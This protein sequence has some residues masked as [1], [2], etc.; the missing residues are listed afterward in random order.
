PA[1]QALLDQLKGKLPA[2]LQSRAEMIIKSLS[3]G[4]TVDDIPPALGPL[5]RRSVQPYAISSFKYD[6]AIEIAKLSIH[7][8]IT[9][10]TTDIQEPAHEANAQ[11]LANSAASIL[12]T[13]ALNHPLQLVGA[14][15]QHPPPPPSPTR[16]EVAD[17]VSGA[18]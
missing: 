18:S 7:F 3:E 5:F 10:A 14:A 17:Q 12:R 8:L 1:A 13:D 4:K 6:P 15:P 11:S 16:G 2:D 9:Q